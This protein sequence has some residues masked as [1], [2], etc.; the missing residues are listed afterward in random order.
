MLILSEG[1]AFTVSVGTTAVSM[2]GIAMESVAVESL[3]AVRESVGRLVAGVWEMT[4][5]GR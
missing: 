3:T 1:T 5:S 4:A 2:S